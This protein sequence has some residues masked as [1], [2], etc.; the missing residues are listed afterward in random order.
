MRRTTRWLA[1][2]LAVLSAATALAQDK[3]PPVK[4][5]MTRLNKPNGLYPA[6]SKQLKADN[7]DWDELQQESKTFVKFAS[8]LGQNTVPHGDPG[9]WAKLTKEY[10]DNAQALSDALGKKDH[11][12]ANAARARLG[13]DAC[14]TC[15]KAHR[16][17]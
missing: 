5:I 1:L 6:I 16:K 13:G 3:P 12:A 15:H 7:P 11:T 9:S 2:G 10:A 14:K 17:S 4:E 8:A